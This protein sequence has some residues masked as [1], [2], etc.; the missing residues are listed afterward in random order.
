MGKAYKCLNPRSVFM[1]DAAKS[2]VVAFKPPKAIS[3]ND[4]QGKL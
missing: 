1:S 2:Q 3:V 4:P